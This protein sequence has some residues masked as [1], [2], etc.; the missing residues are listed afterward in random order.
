MK[1]IITTISLFF[2]LATSLTGQEDRNNVL[3]GGSMGLQFGTISFIDLNPKVGYYLSD[4]LIGGVGGLYKYYKHKRAAGDYSTNIYGGRLFLQ[5]DIFKSIY[6]YGEFEYLTY[7]DYN[8][9]GN[10][11]PFEST[12]ILF[13]GGYR[14]RI[15]SNSYIYFMGL[16]NIDETLK[17]PYNNPVI[18]TG[19]MWNIP[20]NLF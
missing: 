11:V 15:S 6:A 20:K 8:T 16:Y 9:K 5:Y 4:K 13:G 19:F 3:V 7:E 1:A 10:I 14:S 18:R 12:N 2:L 17:T